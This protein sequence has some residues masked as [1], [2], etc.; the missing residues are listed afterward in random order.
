VFDATRLGTVERNVN[1]SCTNERRSE[2]QPQR[3][4]RMPSTCAARV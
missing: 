1:V 3:A 4:Q 2:L